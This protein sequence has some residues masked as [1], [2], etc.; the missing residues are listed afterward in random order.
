MDVLFEC[1]RCGDL[2]DVRYP[3]DKLPVPKSLV[4]FSNKWSTR[5]NRL[6][7]SGVWRFGELLPFCEEQHRVTIG[8]GQTV[9]QQNCGLAAE[10]GM[11]PDGLYLQYEGLNPSGSFK[12]NGMTAAYSHAI[13]VGATASACAS[14]GNTSASMAL[15][16]HSCGLKATV[17]IGEGKI[18]FGKLSQ[19]MD[20]GAYTLQIAG[21]FDDCMRQVQDVCRKLKIYLVNSL[22]P[23]R[24]EGQKTIMFR[25]LEQLGWQIPDWIIVPGGNLGNSSAFGKAFAELKELGLIERIPRLAIVNA[26]GANTLTELVNDRGLRW[27][28]GQV[29]QELIADYYADLDARQYRANT[30][31]SAIEISRPVNLKKCIRAIEVC[32]GV[33]L[34]VTDEEILDAK[35]Q[36]GKYGLG[37]EPASAATIAGLKHLLADGVVGKDQR[38]ACVLTGHLL[39]DPNATVNYHSRMQRTFS[40]PP[41]QVPNDLDRIIDLMKA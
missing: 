18:A 14:T 28:G 13:M 6:D 8:E 12:D 37:C 4:E 26:A 21:D 39:K 32:D 19:A 35:A 17:F 36:I 38:V 15:Y 29:D 3:W 22:N 11:R 10:M 34:A 31:A 9:L 5:H 41:V 27:N 30:I 25:I 16:S 40:N 1:P 2:L 24:L 20:Y 33:V 23:F 7:F